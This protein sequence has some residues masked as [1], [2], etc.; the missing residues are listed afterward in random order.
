[1]TAMEP[2]AL[3][4]RLDALSGRIERRVRELQERGAF[5]GVH[6]DGMKEIHKRSAAI[7]AKLDA[8]IAGGHRWDM[9]KYELVRDFHSLKEDFEEFER[10]LDASIRK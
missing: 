7:Q 1:M 4:E 6:G 9:L 5:S 10:R 8:A 2:D 3:R